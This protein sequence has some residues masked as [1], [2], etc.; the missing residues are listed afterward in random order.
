MNIERS[1]QI[2]ER[3]C[4]MNVH[5]VLDVEMC[6]VLAKNQEYPYRNEIIQ[7]GAVM[8]NDAYEIM[9]KFSTYVR[10]RYGRVDHFIY[11]LTGISER[12]L[13]NAPDI[14]DALDQLLQWIGNRKPTFY[15]WSST[16]YYQI[17]N[18]IHRK[19]QA[20]P[21]WAMIL[22]KEHWIDYQQK[23]GERLDSLRLMKL[24]EALELTEITI[25]GH[26]H[27]GFDDA[28]NTA[29][30]IAKLESN[31]DYLTLLERS[32]AREKDQ[33]PLTVTLGSLMQGLIFESA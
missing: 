25:E 14:Q 20:S 22:E 13:K 8:M 21:K 27:N 32:R 16:D 10:P 5:V 19:C 29:C 31:K 23:L 1:P 3:I 24:T 15:S 17:R 33:K 28:Y 6:K 26:I 2:T 12:V 30:M 9:D 7:I 18:E 4:S 11:A